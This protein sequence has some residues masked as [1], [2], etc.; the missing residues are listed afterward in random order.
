M[1]FLFWLSLS[2]I[3]YVIIGYPLMLFALWWLKGPRPSAEM[4]TPRKVDF[5]I[6]AHNEERVILEKIENTLALDNADDHDIRVLVVSDGST[7]RTVEI[8]RGVDDPRVELVETPGRLGKLAAMNMAMA[9]LT[10]DVIVFSDANAML[11]EEALTCMLRHFED[12]EVGGVC[13]QIKIA[14]K[15]NIAKADSGF[16]SYDQMM[17]RA[18]SDLGG[19]V[20][21]QGSIHSLRRN[22]LAPIPSGVADDF[23]L[24][25]G[26]VAQ[27]YRLVFEPRAHAVEVVTE[28]A[29]EEVRRRIR[30]TEHGWR[31]LMI[32]REVM[33][34]FRFGM[35]SWHIIS[36]KFLRRLVP[37]CLV[38]LLILNLAL[39]DQGWGWYITAIGQVVF[40]SIAVIAY[41]F[42]T[43]RRLPLWGKILFFVMSNVAMAL[44]VI[45]FLRGQH[46]AMWTPT[47]EE[48]A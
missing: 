13:G 47:R 43:T 37:L 22:L 2:L 17:K 28:N 48:D 46:T 41:L 15:G 1:T 5:L 32:L 4:A 21:A 36:H 33:N 30:S 18:E 19:A 8:V 38:M 12:P 11:S 3:V 40:Y 34:P 44:G 31:G 9:H 29:K 45:R 16:W 7:D 42:P 39:A 6:P 25:V 35:Y 10:G 27:G 14:K 26:A 23:I 24:S 20:S